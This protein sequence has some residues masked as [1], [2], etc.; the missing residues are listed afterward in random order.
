M[1]RVSEIIE[2]AR[3][4]DNGPGLDALLQQLATLSS[5]HKTDVFVECVKPVTVVSFELTGNLTRAAANDEVEIKKGSIHHVLGITNSGNSQKELYT[6]LCIGEMR[7]Y[8]V[9]RT[10]LMLCFDDS[11]A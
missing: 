1:A 7:V 8:Y 11:I 5:P 9:S 10:V 4:M 6:L 3:N 2:M